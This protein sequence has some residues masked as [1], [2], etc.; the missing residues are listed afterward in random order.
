M[1]FVT[2]NSLLAQTVGLYR[3]E[4]NPLFPLLTKPQEKL[5]IIQ[6]EIKLQLA[7]IYAD[8]FFIVKPFFPF[9]YQIVT[10]L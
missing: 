2:M 4:K 7:E 3:F 8:K 6:L 10:L 9:Y 1:N 5:L